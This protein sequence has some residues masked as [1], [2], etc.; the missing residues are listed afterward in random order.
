MEGLYVNNIERC[1]LFNISSMRQPFLL[2][3][4]SILYLNLSYTMALTNR[5]AILPGGLGEPPASIHLYSVRG[6]YIQV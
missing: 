3:P 4:F 5:L 6:T 1:I 2:L